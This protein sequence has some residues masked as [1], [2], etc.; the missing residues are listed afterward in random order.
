M[1]IGDYVKSNSVC[2]HTRDEIK[3]KSDDREAG[4]RF[5]N[6]QYDDRQDWTTRS[7]II[8]PS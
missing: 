7:P 3:T 6:R 1:V 2:N 5:V 8:N 4:V